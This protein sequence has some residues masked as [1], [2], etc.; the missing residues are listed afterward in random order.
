MSAMPD[1]GT[2]DARP[3][4][5]PAGAGVSAGRHTVGPNAIIQTRAALDQIAGAGARQAILAAAGLASLSERDPDGM[6]EADIVNALNG[7][8]AARL[9]AATAAAVMERAGALTGDYILANRIPGAA[10]RLLALLPAPLARRMLIRAIAG[11]AW[12]FAGQAQIDTGADFIAI[13]AN[14]LCL[15]RSGFSS[16]IWHV[17]VFRR[18]FTALVDP[19]MTIHETECVG[20][21][22]EACRFGIVKA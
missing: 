17:A 6:V 1:A 9:D 20:H 22:G 15:G 18:L 8:I 11:N 3:F 2:L 4:A 19:A 21:G 5:E 13:N 7:E 16:C 12:T 10:K 14:P